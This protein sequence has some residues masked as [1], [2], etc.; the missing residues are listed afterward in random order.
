MHDKQVTISQ[1]EYD[2]LVA[3]EQTAV[4]AVKTASVRK[5]GERQ[6]EIW[7][8]AIKELAKLLP[9]PGGRRR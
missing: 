1:P 8:T 9:R 2:R 4:G 7:L 5:I 3:I 6:R